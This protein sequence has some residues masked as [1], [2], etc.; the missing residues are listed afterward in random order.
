M[1]AVYCIVFLMIR[2]PPRSTRTD[3]LFPYTTLFRSSACDRESFPSGK[4]SEPAGFAVRSTLSPL[5]HEPMNED[6]GS[7]NA[8]SRRIHHHR[9]SRSEEH[10]SELQSL[11]RISYAVFCLKKKNIK[12]QHLTR[13]SL[14]LYQLR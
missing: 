6:G 2:Q 7:I 1:C 3:T 9:R 4:W 13:T 5:S 12:L 10:T 11:M 14:L 8:Q